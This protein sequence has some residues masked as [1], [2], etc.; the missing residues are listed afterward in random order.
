MQAEPTLLEQ[1]AP[2]A[3]QEEWRLSV[4]IRGQEM[5]E[6]A[7]A[8]SHPLG[9]AAELGTTKVAGHLVD[10]STG[11]ELSRGGVLNTQ[12]G[13]GEDVISRLA[14]AHRNPDGRR[15]LASLIREALNDLLGELVAEAGVTRS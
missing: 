15:Y 9:C 10:L 13:Y 2:L 5:V 8:G 4:F 11:G 12:T 3:R 14:Y 1:L 6:V 7:P